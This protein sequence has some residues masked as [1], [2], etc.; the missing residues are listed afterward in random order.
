VLQDFDWLFCYLLLSYVMRR[1]MCKVRAV[2]CCHPPPK[3]AKRLLKRRYKLAAVFGRRL[4]N[5]YSGF[6]YRYSI[7]PGQLAV[8]LPIAAA[9]WQR[10]LAGALVIRSGV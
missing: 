2:A 8:R 7:T 9:N 3:F 5:S 10:R 4:A 6:S 1:K